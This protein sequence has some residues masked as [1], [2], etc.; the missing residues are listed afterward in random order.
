MLR[1]EPTIFPPLHAHL[2]A[3]A[4]PCSG[5]PV[6]VSIF[7]K[8]SKSGRNGENQKSNER[9]AIF[10]QVL[11]VSSISRCGFVSS[12]SREIAA[13][14][15]MVWPTLINGRAE[16]TIFGKIVGCLRMRKATAGSERSRSPFD[17]RPGDS[18]HVG[19]VTT[20]RSKPP[21]RHPHASGRVFGVCTCKVDSHSWLC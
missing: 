15:Y 8:Q 20:E 18:V 2:S 3:S 7:W 19:R 16:T 10:V 17:A 1:L 11:E 4:I 5:F 12:K 9:A 13:I 14:Y 6:E 21:P